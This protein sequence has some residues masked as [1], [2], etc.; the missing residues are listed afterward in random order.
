MTQ[1]AT[2]FVLTKYGSRVFDYLWKSVEM[3]HREA[4]MEELLPV[5][6]RMKTN[7]FGRYILPKVNFGLY[8]RSTEAWLKEQERFQ[9]QKDNLKEILD[10]VQKKGSKRWQR[11]LDFWIVK[12]SHIYNAGWWKGDQGVEYVCHYVVET[13]L[14]HRVSVN[15]QLD[16]LGK[17]SL[18]VLQFAFSD[19]CACLISEHS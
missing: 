11:L 14:R 5:E 19:S 13:V 15:L 4:I 10:M 7:D 12:D 3:K 16:R 17:F 9:C 1:N 6:S 2:H 8:R 18:A